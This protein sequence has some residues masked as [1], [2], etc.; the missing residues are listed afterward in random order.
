MSS[1]P[2]PGRRASGRCN[3][4]VV[5]VRHEVEKA[6][7]RHLEPDDDRVGIGRLRLL[8][9]LLYVNAPT[10]LRAEVAQTVQREGHVLG[11]KRRAVAPADGGA[12]LDRE[13]LEVDA[14][15]VT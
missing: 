12:R 11:R 2:D 9:E 14:V 3:P 13:L 6:R 1:S 8:H 7:R 4:D 5:L 10:D 15:L